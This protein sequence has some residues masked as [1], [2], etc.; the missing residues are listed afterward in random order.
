MVGEDMKKLGLSYSVRSCWAAPWPQKGSRVS[1]R[2]INSLM[3]E[4]SEA[5]IYI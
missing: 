5:G 2:D 4:G 1:P 3:G